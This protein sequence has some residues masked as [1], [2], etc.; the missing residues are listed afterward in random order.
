LIFLS[1]GR[2]NAFERRL[3][4]FVP[5]FFASGAPGSSVLIVA[6]S[7]GA[8]TAGF[9]VAGFTGFPADTLPFAGAV[10]R[11]VGLPTTG[12]FFTDVFLATDIL[13]CSMTDNSITILVYIT[14]ACSDLTQLMY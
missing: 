6:G 3:R 13:A 10:D 12:V 9:F 14:L 2:E 8:I 4:L 7:T 1:R 11:D 5:A